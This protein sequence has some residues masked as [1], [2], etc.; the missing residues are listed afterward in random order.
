MFQRNQLRRLRSQLVLTFLLSALGIGVAIGLPV[1]LLISRQA[2]SHTQLL[3]EQATSTTRVFLSSELSDLQNLALLT[4][5]RPTLARLLSEPDPS[6]LEDYLN[7][8]REGADLDLLL[9]CADGEEVK[10]IGENISM[11]ELCQRNPQSAYEIFNSNDDLYLYTGVDWESSEGPVYEIVAGKTL[12]RVLTELQNETGLVYFLVLQ[13][14]II[15]SS[16]P[17]IQPTV[18]ESLE[19]Q[20]QANQASNLSLERRSVNI[21]QHEYISSVLDLDPGLEAQLIS[22]L[23]IDDQITTQQNL[24][25]TLTLTLFFIILVAFG[26]GV[27]QSQRLSLPIVNLANIAAKFRQ[28]NLDSPVSIQS[29]V[30]EINQL[31]NTLE[32]ARVA[33]QH[34]MEQLQAEKDWIEHLLNSIVEGTLTL[35]AHNRITFAS[36]GVGK[37]LE[38]E[39]NQIIGRKVDEIFLPAEAE[40]PFSSQLPTTGQ[41]RRVSVKLM[42]GQERLLSISK[43]DFVPPVASDSNRALVIR[44][45]SNEEYIHRLLGDFM[46]NIT[47]EFRTPLAALEAS[48]ELLLDNL[49]NLSQDEIKELLVALNLGIINLQT[50]IDNLIEAASIEAGRFKVSIQPVPFDVILSEAQEIIQPLVEKYGLRLKSS[51]IAEPVQVLADRR[52]TVQIL[53]NLLSNAIKY[54]PDNGLIQINHS[55]QNETLRVEVTDEGRGVPLEQR[56]HLFRRFSHLN[57]SNER[58]KQG[59]GL[60]LSVVKA[61]VEA[62][63]G[64]VGVVDSPGGGSSFWFTLPLANGEER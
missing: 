48:S 54:S 3:L 8:L 31:A 44:D 45:V 50:L 18:D 30:T 43:A 29:S 21:N 59:V 53:V 52:R 6:T 12:S 61:I 28:G 7:T 36:A 5:Q 14:E 16:D 57:A 10:G 58:A 2:S 15:R 13:N 27:W 60:G 46:A 19:L 42:N 34:S 24:V 22:A 35:D 17:L 25:Q 64:E 62:Q 37:I 56:N 47:H 4:S 63:A 1:I 26:L 41:Q 40:I 49:Q 51:P 9:V 23:N 39:P 33:L 20:N 11:A 55:I 32:D 38:Q